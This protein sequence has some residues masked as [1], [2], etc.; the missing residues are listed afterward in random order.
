MEPKKPIGAQCP[1]SVIVGRSQH[2]RDVAFGEKALA[3]FPIKVDPNRPGTPKR[4]GRA[5]LHSFGFGRRTTLQSFRRTIRQSDDIFD[6]DVKQTALGDQ[7]GIAADYKQ[8]LC[9]A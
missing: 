8:N 6:K 2:E 9:T 1:L 7:P 5:L 3:V 4:E